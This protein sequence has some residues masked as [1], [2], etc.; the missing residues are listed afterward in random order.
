MFAFLLVLVLDKSWFLWPPNPRRATEN[1]QARGKGTELVLDH[2]KTKLFDPM[3]ADSL[4]LS[5]V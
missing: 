1:S 4:D 2:K 3:G 5:G